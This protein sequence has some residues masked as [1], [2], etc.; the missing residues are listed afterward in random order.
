MSLKDESEVQQ[1]IQIQAM[2]HGCNLLRNNSGCLP[3][4]TGR[5]VRFGLGNI[6]KKHNDNIKSSDLVGIT[7]VTITKE[8]I[9]KTLGVFTAI[10]VK[11]EGWNVD[12]KFDKREQAQH[13][14]INWVR[15][16]GG[17][18]SFCSDINELK[19]ILK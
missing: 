14:F 11:K 13:N 2:H 7:K 1:L 8:M 10:E 3:D 16:N 4:M 9:G 15:G 5:T 12:K 6:S 18:A 19:D 17:F